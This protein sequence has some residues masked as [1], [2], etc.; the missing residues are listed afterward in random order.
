MN[1]PCSSCRTSFV[2]FKGSPV[3]VGAPSYHTPRLHSVF[4]Q[5]DW[6]P[7]GAGPRKR[8][9]LDPSSLPPAELSSQ[10]WCS[11]PAWLSHHLK[12]Q[13]FTQDFPTS[14]PIWL[15]Y[16]PHKYPS[17]LWSLD[18]QSSKTLPV[19][20]HLW[21]AESTRATFSTGPT[22]NLWPWVSN[23]SSGLSGNSTLFP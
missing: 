10:P 2:G 7:K 14:D 18:G 20:L 16:V 15:V 9:W 11:F 1:F 22:L 4:T 23:M 19:A 3:T 13:P 8:L 5:H 6:L 12:S 21:A 17:F